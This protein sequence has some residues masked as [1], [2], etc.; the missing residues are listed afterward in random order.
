M[1]TSSLNRLSNVLPQANQQGADKKGSPRVTTPKQSLREKETRTGGAV[2]VVFK[3]QVIETTDSVPSSSKTK[4]AANNLNKSDSG[5]VQ[6]RLSKQL[7]FDRPEPT[8][9]LP[10][11]W[12]TMKRRGCLIYSPSLE[13]QEMVFSHLLLVLNATVQ[14]QIT[15]D[16]DNTLT[17]NHVL[18][19]FQLSAISKDAKMTYIVIGE[20]KTEIAWSHT[21]GS[22]ILN[23]E[24]PPGTYKVV[25][26]YSGTCLNRSLTPRGKSKTQLVRSDPDQGF[27]LTAKAREAI[28]LLFQIYDADMNQ[29]WSGEE[30]RR[31]AKQ[32]YQRADVDEVWDAVREFCTLKNDQLPLDE[33]AELF[34][35]EIQEDNGNPDCLWN[36][37]ERSGVNEN[38]QFT[39]GLSV[40]FNVSVAQKQQNDVKLKMMDLNSYKGLQTEPK[41]ADWALSKVRFLS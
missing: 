9:P 3:D 6:F 5:V 8:L 25:P 7:D 32:T 35:R 41:V 34:I 14:L 24:L 40:L 39:G 11:G 15:L 37:L 30:F 22:A 23:T 21:N 12:M 38:L 16:V 33:L 36:A 20:N 2:S 18:I 31:F 1:M 27:T 29:L 19:A 13:I 10:N 17:P 26:I 4:A 28:Q